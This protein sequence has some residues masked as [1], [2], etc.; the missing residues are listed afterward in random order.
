M[1]HWRI[2]VIAPAP[3][4]REPPGMASLPRE[5]P[6]ALADLGHT[7]RVLYP[8]GGETPTP[9]RG[10]VQAIP[11]RIEPGRRSASRTSAFGRKLAAQ[12]DRAADL[13]L[14][15][16]PSAGS[17][18]IVPGP[19]P[20]YAYLAEGA[21][22]DDPRRAPPGAA[23]TGL[24]GRAEGWWDRRVLRGLE[25]SAIWRARL[26]FATSPATAERLATL[27]RVPPERIRTVPP[28]LA[29]ARPAGTKEEARL[30]LHVPPDVPV[31]AFVGQDPAAEGFPIALAAFRKV[32]ALFPGARLLAVRGPWPPEPGVVYIP[33]DDAASR[34][35][36][37]RAADVVIFP[38]PAAAA[39]GVPWDALGYGAALV[40]SHHVPTQALGRVGAIRV[41]ASDDPGDYASELAELLADPA[42]RRTLGDAGQA[43]ADT[44][45]LGRMAERIEREILLITPA[46]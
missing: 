36:V 1:S 38:A 35:L 5:L 46:A 40:V 25:E 44:L 6:A 7:V 19:G 29:P 42:L 27:Y 2:D 37:L 26:V 12:M 23:R 18:P 22:V 45:T 30:A 16:D 21:A 28:A 11:I 14:A 43:L 10:S 3:A 41:V 9:G 31:T 13:W 34:A 32:R 20:L 33:S 4:D 39:A 8:D 15:L 17:L 24:R